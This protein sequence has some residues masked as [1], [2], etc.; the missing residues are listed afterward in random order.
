MRK[1]YTCRLS[2]GKNMKSFKVFPEKLEEIHIAQ[3]R[4]TADGTRYVSSYDNFVHLKHL[5]T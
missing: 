4:Q 3:P 2:L 1:L 5:L